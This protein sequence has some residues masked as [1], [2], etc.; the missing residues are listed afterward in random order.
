MVRAK[1]QWNQQR[2]TAASGNWECSR[3]A[4]LLELKVTDSAGPG[5]AALTSD[6]K[7]KSPDTWA[8]LDTAALT[9][10]KG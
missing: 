7:V 3:T 4:T 10:A 2:E 5:A 1:R 9:T 6:T 8:C